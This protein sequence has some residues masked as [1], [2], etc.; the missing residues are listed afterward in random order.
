[1]KALVKR[2][3]ETRPLAGGCPRA[4]SR[5][6]RRAD[7]RG[8]HRHLRHRPAHLQVGRLG[9]A[10]H[11]GADGRRPRVCRRGGGGRLQREGFLPGR[12]GQRRR[13]RGLRALPQ[14]PGGA[15][16]SVQR[17]A[18]HRRQ[19]AGRLC[20]V[21]LRADDQRVAS[22]GR[23]RPRRG[24]HLRSVRQRGAHGAVVSDV[25]GEDVLI[26]GAGPDRHHGGGGGQA[27]RGAVCGGDGCERL[28][29]RPGAGRWA[30]RV[31]LNVTNGQPRARCRSS[32]A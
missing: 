6:Q 28:P 5:H 2:E 22:P 8:P 18:G 16:A 10:D 27:C 30:P 1:M 21:H 12:S 20:G 11:P 3:A 13:P 25:L 9:A 29:A 23:H 14:L 26:T 19:P 24:R 32:W 7:P 15:A 4:A 31:A 17:H